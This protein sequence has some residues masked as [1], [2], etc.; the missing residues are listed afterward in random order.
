ME[1]QIFFTLLICF[2]ISIILYLFIET[3]RRRINLPPGSLGIPYVGQTLTLLRAMKANKAEKWLSDRIE[4]H[5]PVSKLTLFGFPTVLL[6]G[7]EANRFLFSSDSTVMTLQQP[8]SFRKIFGT[9]NLLEMSGEE[10]RRMRA[11]FMRFLKPEML[12]EYVGVMDGEVRR[13]L[14][15]NWRGKETVT[16]FPLIKTLTFDIMC[17]LFFGLAQC[18][19]KA[20]MLRDFSHIMDGIWSIPLDLPF[21]S[22]R[23]SVQASAGI[24][25][26]LLDIIQ[27][28]RSA[29]ESGLASSSHG[30]LITCFLSMGGGVGPEALTEEEVMDNSLLAMTAGH[31]TTSIVLVFLIRRLAIDAGVYEAVLREQEGIAQTKCPGET[32]TWEDLNKM[33]YTW[34]A[35]K[36]TM[37]MIPPIFGNVR[38]AVKDIEYNGYVI[39]KGW[40][41]FWAASPTHMDERIFPTRPDSIPRTS[42]TSRTS[43]LRI[44]SWG[45]EQARGSVRGTSSR[46]SR[47]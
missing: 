19:R 26:S 14:E 39:P 3:K 28:K 47:S 40:Q 1:D 23:R 27:A 8:Q 38:R 5:G 9:R 33:D 29:L 41:I 34:R 17:T 31:E 44:L 25:R 18:P 21:T 4:R 42:M 7:A 16:V 22:F 10:H 30:D 46:G 12:K 6:A 20:Q 32:L 15:M 13:H 24:R 2:I 37:R 11:V 45:L 43:F 35:A 36:E